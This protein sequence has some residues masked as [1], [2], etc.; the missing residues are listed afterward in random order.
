[1]IELKYKDYIVLFKDGYVLLSKREISD[2]AIS[3]FPVK[4]KDKFNFYE[5]AVLD[6]IKIKTRIRKP[7]VESIKRFLKKEGY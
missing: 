4:Y 6:T 3:N 2:L 5:D 7:S 1:M